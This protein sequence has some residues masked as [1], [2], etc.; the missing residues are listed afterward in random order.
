MMKKILLG[1]VLLFLF[2]PSSAFAQDPN[3]WSEVFDDHGNLRPDLIDLGVTT[4]HPDWMSVDLPF[5]QSIDLEANYHRYQTSNGDLII[6]PSA[7]TLFF[8]AMNPQESG[9]SNAMGSVGNGFNGLITFLGAIAGNNLD[10]NRI[11]TD[12]PEFKTPDQYWNAV[13]DGKVNAW[14]YFSGWGFINTLFFMSENDLAMRNAYL[15]YLQGAKNCVNIPGGCSG[16][17]TPPPPQDQCPDPKVSVPKPSLEIRKTA[18]ANALVIGQDPQNKRGADV[19]ATV[20]IPPVIFTWYEPIYEKRDVC[21]RPRAGESPNCK[22]SSEA[23]NDDGVKDTER[24][25]KGC[26][27]HVER[28][29]DAVTSMQANAA[30][31]AASQ[32]WITTQLGQTHYGAFI[33]QTNYTLIPGLG[34]WSGNCSGDGTC[35]ARGQA[36]KIPFSDPGTYNLRLIV[37]TKGAS[38]HGVPIT[39]PRKLTSDGKMQVFLTLPALVP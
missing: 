4:D 8:M 14:T 30:L 15:M 32:G 13:V 18:P 35:V 2:I 34:T 24:V 29:P 6:L 7:S 9:L 25:F 5:G 22:T 10:W 36:L 16:I 38:F 27:E 17:V 28:L 11:V 23:G 1:I 3:P 12:H 37:T 33:H 20:T 39:Q 31:D 19:Q 26:R 21:R